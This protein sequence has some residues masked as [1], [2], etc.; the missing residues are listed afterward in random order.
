MA[1]AIRYVSLWKRGYILV[2]PDDPALAL[3]EGVSVVGTRHLIPLAAFTGKELKALAEKGEIT[4]DSDPQDIHDQSFARSLLEYLQRTSGRARRPDPGP[5]Y[6]DWTKAGTFGSGELDEAHDFKDS[7][8]MVGYQAEI[9]S[10][11][12]YYEVWVKGRQL[13]IRTLDNARKAHRSEAEKKSRVGV[14]AWEAAM[15]EAWALGHATG[16]GAAEWTIQDTIGGRA[17]GDTRA[18]AAAIVK[19]YE[20][21]DP[22][23]LDG[24]KVPNLS[25]EFADSMTPEKLIGQLG[26]AGMLTPEEESEIS[27]QWEDAASE[28]YWDTLI[29]AARLEAG[30]DNPPQAKDLTLIGK[31]CILVETDSERYEENM[32][33]ILGYPDGSILI[34]GKFVRTPKGRIVAIEYLDIGK[35]RAE[36]E[37]KDDIR[38]WRHDVSSESL[39]IARTARGLHIKGPKRLWEVC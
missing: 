33:R 17:S 3:K 9:R 5:E 30:L 6:K 29:V 39:T 23:V 16:V 18:R 27:T 32:G 34:E 38:P 14:K 8:T 1:E 20:D 4:L 11:P 21:G 10:F 19:G 26:L 15:K 13:F 36:G 25:G 31:E 37:P 2:A 7:F 35:A 12:G 28:G 22:M 24:F